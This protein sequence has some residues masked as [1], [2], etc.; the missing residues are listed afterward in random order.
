MLKLNSK[1]RIFKKVLCVL[2]VIGALITSIFAG[3]NI[4]YIKTYVKGSSMAPTF[5][6]NVPDGEKGDKIYINRF[7]KGKRDDIIVLKLANEDDEYIIKR[8]I[9]LE[10]DVVNIVDD[11]D[12]KRYNLM[13]NDKIFYTKPYQFDN[14]GREVEYNTVESFKSYIEEHKTDELRVVKD[15][16]EHIKGVSIKKGEVYLLGDNWNVSK[17]SSLM[18]PYKYKNIIGRVDFIVE[19]GENEFVE[20]LKR[21]F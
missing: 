17:D 9:A 4:V 12:N 15:E 1:A 2:V 18:G 16:D 21:I 8:L 6:L 14:F 19:K 13:V 5:N 11:E 10:G 3:F 7:A 20:I